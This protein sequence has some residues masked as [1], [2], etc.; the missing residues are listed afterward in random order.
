MFG[1]GGVTNL[2]YDEKI[3]TTAMAKFNSTILSNCSSK[4]YT[5]GAVPIDELQ[6]WEKEIG[7]WKQWSF[8]RTYDGS[9]GPTG[10]YKP[11]FSDVKFDW[12]DKV[13]AGNLQTIGDSACAYKIVNDSGKPE[14][15]AGFIEFMSSKYKEKHKGKKYDFSK[16]I[17]GDGISSTDEKSQCLLPASTVSNFLFDNDDALVIDLKKNKKN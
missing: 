14:N 15:S 5:G 8:K 11:E 13:K 4:V 10:E 6:W 9:K 16:Y 7:Q 12:K 3:G 2:T 17:S 1:V